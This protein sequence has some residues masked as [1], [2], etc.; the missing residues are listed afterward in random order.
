MKLLNLSAVHGSIYDE[1]SREWSREKIQPVFDGYKELARRMRDRVLVS[2]EFDDEQVE[3]MLSVVAATLT[4][5]VMEMMEYHGVIDE[6]ERE[7]LRTDLH[8]ALVG[9]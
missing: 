6:D 2:N 9:N 4:D 1:D 7:F 8:K 5:R 3:E